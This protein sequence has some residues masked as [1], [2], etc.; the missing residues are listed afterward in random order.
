MQLSDILGLFGGLAMFLLGMHLMGEG[1]ELLAGSRL[2]SILE[3]VTRNRFIAMLIGLVLTAIIQ[4]SNA[5]TAMTVGFVGA[6]LME[7]SRAIGI[8][9]GANI[10]TTVTGQLIA[11][12]ITQ[13]A[14]LFLLFGVVLFVYTKSKKKIYLGQ[15]FV[16]LG[17]LFMGM[18]LMGA[19]ME[20]LKDVP[21]FTQTMVSFKN[22]LIGVAVGTIFTMLV[23]SASV[24]IGVM[25]ALALQGLVGL[26]SAVYVLCGQN[27]GCTIA[28]ILASI[29]GNK[30]AKRTALVHLLFNV[31]GTILFI[32][33]C[34]VTPYISWVESMTPNN[35]AAQIANANT[36]F[37][38]VCM[39]IL[40]PCAGLLGRLTM[41]LI[42]GVDKEQRGANQLMHIAPSFVAASIGFA[43]VHAE[44]ERMQ[45]LAFQN[46]HKA[47][48]S[49]FSKEDIRGEIEMNEETIDYLNK[50]ITNAL[51]RLNATELS[52]GD[53]DR[54]SSMY[55]VISDLERI[56]DHAENISG[57][58]VTIRT[59][60]KSFSEKA[61]EGLRLLI[62]KVYAINERA[63]KHFRDKTDDGMKEI[64][65]MEQ[66]IDDITAMLQKEHIKRLVVNECT[67]DLGMLYVEILT[68]LERIADHA[69]NI[70][71]AAV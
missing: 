50:E 8:I 28:A 21:W 39:A 27:I 54:I 10:G 55:H 53:A 38:V 46:L 47:I 41:I 13:Y 57:Y 24:S 18:K 6:G 63:Y 19:S 66:E 52:I 12:N 9:M 51:I 49:L 59:N 4:S 43:Q 56:G 34:R 30:D 70:A 42:P 31:I 36:I 16:G 3:K 69:L 23:Q 67:P 62:E 40:L 60:G 35:V 26:N 71:E 17:I 45:Q 48:D 11:L 7:F 33:V 25:Q 5:V 29:G 65:R 61:I 44:I 32:I 14:P 22:P 64:Q 1:M 68:D 37:N 58:A 20:P 15:I 2:R